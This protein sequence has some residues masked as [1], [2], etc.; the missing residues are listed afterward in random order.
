MKVER[1]R[2]D[3]TNRPSWLISSVTQLVKTNFLTCLAPDGNLGRS[4]WLLSSFKSLM[5]HCSKLGICRV[6]RK[7]VV[8]TSAVVWIPRIDTFLVYLSKKGLLRTEFSRLR[9]VRFLRNPVAMKRKR[10][11]FARGTHAWQT[12]AHAARLR[13]RPRSK[14]LA[15]WSIIVSQTSVE[16]L[17]VRLFCSLDDLVSIILREAKWHTYRVVDGGLSAESRSELSK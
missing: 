13:V 11:I 8:S 6:T 4:G 10:C 2:N 5:L 12:R 15:T 3:V 17:G 1:D 9:K 7:R 16:S 14:M